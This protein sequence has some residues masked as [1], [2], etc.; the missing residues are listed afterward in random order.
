MAIKGL[1]AVAGRSILGMVIKGL[2]AVT[3]SWDCD[4]SGLVV[5]YWD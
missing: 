2:R 1:R 5:V 3:V 4:G